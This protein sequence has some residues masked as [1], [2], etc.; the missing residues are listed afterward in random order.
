MAVLHVY[1][2]MTLLGMA[3]SSWTLHLHPHSLMGHQDCGKDN[4][5]R[6]PGLSEQ[7]PTTDEACK[8]A[9]CTSQTKDVQM[10]SRRFVADDAL[11]AGC[12]GLVL[13]REKR[14]N[15]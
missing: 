10:Q 1:H 13:S 4:G 2:A 9:S 12:D 5:L 6:P 15:C 11:F 3:I 7:L 14:K 8:N